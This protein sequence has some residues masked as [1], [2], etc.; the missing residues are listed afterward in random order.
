MADLNLIQKG[1]IIN[2][3]M[4]TPGI[5]G[6]QY[7]GAIVVSV[8]PYELAQLVDT[9]VAVKH[10][11]FY[12]FFKDKV[13]NVNNPA[14]YNYFILQLDKTKSDMIAIGFPWINSDSIKS[15]TTRQANVTIKNFQEFQRAPLMDFLANIGSPY[16]LTITDN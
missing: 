3:D 5:F 1:D 6:A 14:I 8:A 10:A 13:N 15:I 4:I 11:A 12:P 7:K 9:S 16:E 2:F